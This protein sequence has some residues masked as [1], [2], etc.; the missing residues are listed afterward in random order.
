M[1]L[2]SIL[3]HRVINKTRGMQVAEVLEPRN[4]FVLFYIGFGSIVKNVIMSMTSE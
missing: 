1:G 2:S 4:A 3:S